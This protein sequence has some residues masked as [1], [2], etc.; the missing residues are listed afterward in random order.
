MTR[1]NACPVGSAST[2]VGLRLPPVLPLQSRL[3]RLGCRPK[4]L[5]LF[6]NLSC[7]ILT[8]PLLHIVQHVADWVAPF[9]RS[10]YFPYSSPPIHPYSP[11]PLLY[12]RELGQSSSNSRC[13]TLFFFKNVAFKKF[14]QCSLKKQLNENNFEGLMMEYSSLIWT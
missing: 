10:Q 4:T 8:E 6:S 7:P 3:K 9:L 2:S 13:S 1:L 11:F 12:A 14:L 5:P